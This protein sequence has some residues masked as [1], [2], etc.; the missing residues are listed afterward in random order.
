MSCLR[1]TTFLKRKKRYHE[2]GARGDNASLEIIVVKI[3]RASN[4]AGRKR[5]TCIRLDGSK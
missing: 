4:V 1:E 3:E 2:S 5:L